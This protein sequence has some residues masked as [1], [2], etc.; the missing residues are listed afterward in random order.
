MVFWIPILLAMVVC[1]VLLVCES[2]PEESIS[3]LRNLTSSL[4]EERAM[5]TLRR[6]S[7]SYM[8]IP[9]ALVSSI[10]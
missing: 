10:I 8:A 1:L 2:T 7:I 6:Y 3:T 4:R 5:W 9:R